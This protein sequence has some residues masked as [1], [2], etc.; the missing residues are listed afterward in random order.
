MLLANPAPYRRSFVLLF[1]S[2]Y[3][4]R[5]EEILQQCEVGL[6]G[7]VTGTLFNM[8]VIAVLNGIALL[9][10]ASTIGISE[11]RSIGCIIVYS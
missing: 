8:I 3:R 2:S 9:M 4:H 11:W 6:G 5:V 7:W 1:P 10:G